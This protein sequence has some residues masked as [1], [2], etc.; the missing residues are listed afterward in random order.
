MSLGL[1]E[2]SRPSGRNSL[3]QLP[4][5]AARARPAS[6]QTSLPRRTS[7]LSSSARKRPSHPKC[8]AST[9]RWARP[10]RTATSMAM[11]RRSRGWRRSNA[12]CMMTLYVSLH[13]LRCINILCSTQQTANHEA[14]LANIVSKVD[15]DVSYH[16]QSNLH[17][18]DPGLLSLSL[19]LPP[20]RL[21]LSAKKCHSFCSG[22]HPSREARHLIAS[23]LGLDQFCRRRSLLSHVPGGLTP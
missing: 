1:N 16:L 17:F 4:A 2:S 9:L 13:D 23:P 22:R 11:R 8:P 6:R 5:Q 14:L 21:F 20:P 3:R 19:N 10:N 7:R 18:L 15:F 12:E